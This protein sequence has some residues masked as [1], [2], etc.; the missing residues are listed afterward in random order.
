MMKLMLPVIRLK[1]GAERIGKGDF[2]YRIDVTSKDEIGELAEGFNKMAQ[3]LGSLQSMEEK[4]SQAERLAAIGKFAAGI[5][6]EINNPIGN[7]I[8]IAKLMQRDIQDKKL[9]EDIESIIKDADRCARITKD[10]LAYSRQSP[11]RKEMTSLNTIVDDT[12]NAIKH[13]LDSKSIEIRKELYADLPEIHV[14][15]LQISQVVNNI[16]LN[17]VQSIESSGSITIKTVHL[18]NMA[19]ISIADTGCGIDN[20]IKDK[21]FYPFFTTKAVGE[22]TGLGLAISYGIIQNHDGEIIA[23]SRKGYGSAFRIRL[24]VGEANG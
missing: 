23:E 2:A 10:L 8:G 12:V 3:D 18:D 7:M 20:D 6:H 5:A 4:L 11:P 1:E 15:A 19:E 14:D 22:G 13:N 16:L 17:A 21:I 9:S 24:P